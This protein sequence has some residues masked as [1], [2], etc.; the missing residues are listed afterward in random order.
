M[1]EEE[2]EE[3]VITALP[4]WKAIKITE[5]ALWTPTLAE[6]PPPT[7]VPGQEE[8]PTAEC[9]DP[10]GVGWGGPSTASAQAGCG[11]APGEPSPG[12][13]RVHGVMRERLWD[14]GLLAPNQQD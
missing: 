6:E 3:S 8:T 5:L 10:A 11:R 4:K 13:S 7:D 12:S 2:E 14:P 1:E 9:T